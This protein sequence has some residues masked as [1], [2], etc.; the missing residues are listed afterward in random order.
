[1]NEAISGLG[2][3]GFWLFLAILVVAIVWA[4]VRK[5][6]I[7]QEALIR[8]VESGQS[9]DKELIENIFSSKKESQK[10]YDPTR[11]VLEGLGF[12]FLMGFCTVFAG[13]AWKGGISYPIAG[14]G[15]FAILWSIFSELRLEKQTKELEKQKLEGIE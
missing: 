14:L 11:T 15:V 9:L 2:A 8:I 12:C 5:A 4:V 7:R 6:Q 13:F 10:P 3:L 1:M